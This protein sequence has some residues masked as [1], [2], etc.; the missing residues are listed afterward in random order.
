MRPTKLFTGLIGAMALGLSAAPAPAQDGSPPGPPATKS[1]TTGQFPAGD[2]PKS[3]TSD[4]PRVPATARD[5]APPGTRP[6]R[7]D[8]PATADPNATRVA[9]KPAANAG[10]IIHAEGVVTRID[11]AGKTINGELERFAFD[12]SQDWMAY[13]NKGVEGIPEKDAE[14]PKTTAAQKDANAKVH[15]DDADRP[16]ILEMAITKRTYTYTHARLD[17]GTDVYAAATSASP[18][19]S[20]SRTGLI[21]TAPSAGQTAGAADRPQATNFT[22]LKE[23]SFVSVRYRK[24]GDVNEVLNLTIIDLP[25]N[26]VPDAALPARTGA[27]NRNSEGVRTPAVPLNPVGTGGL[28]K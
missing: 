19:N 15:G 1:K 23:G 5:P 24:V 13:V 22:N 20:T 26:P 4:A 21:R 10:R 8:A 14:R 16:T 27:A 28:P 7:V 9:R 17:D 12:P 6:V 25:L 18:D 3:P 11:R 2:D